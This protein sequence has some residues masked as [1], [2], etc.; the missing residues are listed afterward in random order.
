MG[1]RRPAVVLQGAQIGPHAGNV[2][3]IGAVNLAGRVLN[4][5]RPGVDSP[6]S[7]AK[8]LKQIALSGAVRIAFDDAIEDVGC[9]FVVNAAS[10]PAAGYIVPGYRAVSQ[11]ER[12]IILNVEPSSLSP[13]SIA[14]DCCVLNCQV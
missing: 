7:S 9:A 13:G 12:A 10:R 11:G 4:Q 8:S 3:E 5:A 2:I 6:R 1:L 14:A